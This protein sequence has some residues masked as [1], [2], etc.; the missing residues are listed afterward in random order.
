MK[1]LYY[2][3]YILGLLFIPISLICCGSDNENDDDDDWSYSHPLVGCWEIT[4]RNYN[5]FN[6]YYNTF[7]EYSNFKEALKID[8]NM[9]MYFDCK[10]KQL[11]IDKYIEDRKKEGTNAEYLKPNSWYA[12]GKLQLRIT[13]DKGDNGH[14]EVISFFVP[15]PEEYKGHGYYQITGDQLEIN[16][17]FPYAGASPPIKCRR[18]EDFRDQEMPDDFIGWW[19]HNYRYFI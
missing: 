7:N 16:Y 19:N 5:T 4:E 6:E 13:S 12:E 8:K 3:I 10:F 2:I 11:I 1:K 17:G 15:D 18:M 14:F 9:I